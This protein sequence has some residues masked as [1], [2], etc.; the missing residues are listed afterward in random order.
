MIQIKEYVDTLIS[1][2]RYDIVEEKKLF[3][4]LFDKKKKIKENSK[5]ILT[6]EYVSKKVKENKTTSIANILSFEY[7]KYDFIELSGSL[8]NKDEKLILLY[9]DSQIII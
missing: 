2:K 9:K 4:G 6:N 1:A 8:K 5:I 7:N 3:G